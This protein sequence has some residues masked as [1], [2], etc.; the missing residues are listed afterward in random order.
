MRADGEAKAAAPEQD[1]Q[2]KAM[3]SNARQ[4]LHTVDALRAISMLY[5]VGFWH[6][7]EYAPAAPSFRTPLFEN[8]IVGVLGV[9]VFVSGLLLGRKKLAL[10]SHDLQDFYLRRFLRIYPLYLA[11]LAVFALAGLT[12]WSTAVKSAFGLSM[13]IGP[14]PFTLWF[15]AMLLWFYLLAPLLISQA[16]HIW[17]FVVIAGA[18]AGFF[19]LAG[20]LLPQADKRLL[21]YFP[22]FA[23]GILWSSRSITPRVWQAALLGIGA[24][25]AAAANMHIQF[26]LASVM[27]A[28]CVALFGATTAYMW[29]EIMAPG[30]GA[31]RWL[32]L[33]SYASF[34]MYLFHRPILSLLTGIF[35]PAG[36]LPQ[37]A[38]LWCAGLPLVVLVAWFVQRG[39]DKLAAKDG[40]AGRSER[41]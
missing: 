39:Y 4:R 20:L 19:G 5:I 21:V 2:M 10:N 33:V 36:F 34:A 22:V 26:G 40:A 37:M 25:L 29:V 17:R 6:L 31:N 3:A 35:L 12:D 1:D 11:G 28:A 41:V 14:P 16:D 7:F 8:L 9:F 27:L 18:V 30:L 23:A 32:V 15:V 38:F 13:F 24:L